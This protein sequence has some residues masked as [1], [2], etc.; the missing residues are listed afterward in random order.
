[1]GKACRHRTTLK[2]IEYQSGNVEDA[3]LIQNTVN[4]GLLEADVEV[5]PMTEAEMV[6]A[7]QATPEYV[8]EQDRQTQRAADIATNLPSWAQVNTSID[9]ISNLAEA[10]VFIKKLARVVYWLV[11][12]RAE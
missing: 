12:E 11:R 3:V 8:A 6:A 4:G 9:N 7:I 5:V 1:M 2:L 10:K